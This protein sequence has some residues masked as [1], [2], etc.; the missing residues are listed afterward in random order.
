MPFSFTILGPGA[1]LILI[2]A[3]MVV[4]LVKKVFGHH[5]TH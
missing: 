2:G 3:I 1:V 5:K 4:N